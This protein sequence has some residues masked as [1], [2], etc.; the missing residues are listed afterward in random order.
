M[1]STRTRRGFTLIELLVVIAIISILLTMLM[2]SIT[3]ARDEAKLM[4]C[5]NNL[6]QIMG[7]SIVYAGANKGQLPSPNWHYDSEQI[8]WLYAN[9]KMVEPTDLEGGQ[10]WPYLSS[11]YVYRCPADRQPTASE[12]AAIGWYPYDSRMITSYC[13]NGSPCGYSRTKRA[14]VAAPP[15]FEKSW[16]YLTYQLSQYRTDD[17]LYWEAEDSLS[18]EQKGWWWDGSNT[19]DQGIATNRHYRRGSIACADGHAERIIVTNYYTLAKQST[20]NRLWNVPNSANG[21]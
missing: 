5:G 10:L 7:A 1:I 9:A 17:V 12:S 20:R 11:V 13:M 2:P 14:H 18:A 3:R 8:G 15:P 19:P 6:R 21:R 4:G 16:Q